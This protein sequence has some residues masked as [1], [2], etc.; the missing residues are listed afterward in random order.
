MLM[1]S[2][3]CKVVNCTLDQDWTKI[4]SPFIGTQMLNKYFCNTFLKENLFLNIQ[5]FN[6]ISILLLDS[7]KV[8]YFGELQ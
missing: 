1:P 2:N 6:F 8:P 7:I 5:F 4:L 3:A